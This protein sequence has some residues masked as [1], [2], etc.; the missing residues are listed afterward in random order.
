MDDSIAETVIVTP[1]TGDNKSI[2]IPI[3]I[4]VV[5]LVILATGVVL[6]R[7]KAL[8]ENKDNK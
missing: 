3:S 4:G 6:I 7:K 5:A 2:I 8:G 1:S